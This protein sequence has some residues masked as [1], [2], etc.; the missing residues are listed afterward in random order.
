MIRHYGW[1]EMLKIMREGRELSYQNCQIS[2]LQARGIHWQH[3]HAQFCDAVSAAGFDILKSRLCFRNI[4]DM[5]VVR[6]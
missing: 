6:K 3:S 1:W 2:K 4:S 5:V